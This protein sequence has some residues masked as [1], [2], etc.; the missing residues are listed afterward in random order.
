MSSD[1][2]VAAMTRAFAIA[3]AYVESLESAPAGA[4]A[5]LATLRARL[6]KPFVSEGID[7][8]QVIDDLAAD[9]AGGLLGSAGGR[10]FGW[11]IGGSLPAAIG[12]DWLASTYDQNSAL[13]ACGPA[14]A[15]VEEVAGSWVKDLLNL[16]TDASFALTSGCQMAHATCLAAARNALLSDRQWDV[17]ERGLGGAPQITLVTSDAAHGSVERAIRLLGIGKRSIIALPADAS[18]RLPPDELAGE[19]WHRHGDPLI[20]LLQAGDINTGVFDDY[21]TLIPMSRRAG[22]WVHVDGAFGLWAAASSMKRHLVDGIG[23]ADSWAT[24]GHKW[25][26]LPYDCG[27]AFVA[28]AAAHRAAV[29]HRASY[30]T[31]DDHARDQIDWNLEWSRRGRGFALYA[32]LRE[33]GRTGVAELV[34]RT[35][36]HAAALVDGMSEIRGVEVLWRPTLNQGLVRFPDDR[37]DATGSDHDHRTDEVIARIVASGEAFFGGTTWRGMRAMRISVCN[38]RTDERDVQRAI[39]AVAEAVC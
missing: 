24:D 32:G 27:L 19:L 22:A 4:T 13:Y 15:V 33:L 9:V 14:A 23:L 34:D 18:G 38:W 6:A 29:S 5:D 30:L 10:F 21:E 8:A 36:R 16:P 28:R 3:T 7:P 39:R 35:C 25:L 12:A 11:V 20:V 37:P 1:R 26:N 17:E 2:T 31:H